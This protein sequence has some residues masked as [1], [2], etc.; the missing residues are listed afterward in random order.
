MNLYLI[1]YRATGKSTLGRSL[2]AELNLPFVDLD[3]QIVRDAGSSI[4]AM[5]ADLGWAAF[6]NAEQEVLRGI[7]RLDRQVVATGGGVILDAENRA[8]LQSTGVVVWLQATWETIHGRME[9]DVQTPVS[10]PPLSERALADEIRATLM[11]RGPYYARIA[12]FSVITDTVPIREVV[13]LI[14]VCLLELPKAE[15][16]LTH[17]PQVE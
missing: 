15:S 5:V 17:L 12:D 6:R 8:L 13:D 7:A 3:E 16:L 14:R 4:A 9:A 11:A 2:A 1:G 10:R